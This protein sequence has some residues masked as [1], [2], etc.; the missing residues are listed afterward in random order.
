MTTFI[1][2]Q[3]T[4]RHEWQSWRRSLREFARLLFQL[5][6]FFADSAAQ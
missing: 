3:H 1:C 2:R 4:T 5:R 6:D